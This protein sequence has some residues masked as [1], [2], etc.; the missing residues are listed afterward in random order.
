MDKS[1]SRI[2]SEFAVG[3]KYQDLPKDVVYEVKRYIY[4]SVG[5]ALGGYHTKDVNI[6][7]NIYKKMGGKK[8]STVIGFGDQI[9]AVNS[10]FLNS[11][12]DPCPR[13]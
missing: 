2:I 11:L 1:I 3:L 9:P 13:F 10:S 8:E 4:D 7:R 12:N 6:L 5:C